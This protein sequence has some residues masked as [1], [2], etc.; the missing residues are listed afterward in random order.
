MEYKELIESKFISIPNIVA[1]SFIS[2]DAK[3]LYGYI[4]YW[5]Y[6]HDTRKTLI[7][8][9]KAI[10]CSENTARK[11][12]KEL[13]QMKFLR[14]ETINKFKNYTTNQQLNQ[15]EKNEIIDKNYPYS[16]EELKIIEKEELEK[17]GKILQRIKEAEEQLKLE[18]KNGQ[19]L[20]QK[21]E[22]EINAKKQELRRIIEN[23]QRLRSNLQKLQVETNKKLDK[24]EMKEKNE[25]YEK[26]KEKRQSSLEQLLKVKERELFNSLQ[27]IDQKK[28][29][30]NN[31]EKLLEKNVDMTQ[32]NDLY[33]KI[34]NANNEMEKL[35]KEKESLE[36][37]KEEHNCCVKKQQD[38]IKEIQNLKEELR[39]IQIENR[40]KVNEDRKNIYA[41]KNEEQKNYQKLKKKNNGYIKNTNKS[42]ELPLIHNN[43]IKGNNNN[44]NEDRVL[45]KYEVE[46][47]LKKYDDIEK[48]KKLIDKKYSNKMKELNKKKEDMEKKIQT[49]EEQIKEDENKNQIL[50]SETEEQKKEIIELQKN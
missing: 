30:K 44:N 21:K 12:I 47:Y 15:V 45:D 17:Q 38:V 46:E 8:I 41:I 42:S 3:L 4:R 2:N 25:V 36:K 20:S 26:E 29:K 14:V 39:Y 1:D 43:L 48:E 27:I 6:M 5:D 11:C 7:E 10:N 37:I 19:N 28:K 49:Y 34:N 40:N 16:I 22:S 24:M 31:L 32:I 35:E 33:N 50:T 13:E 9:S 23:N 18:K